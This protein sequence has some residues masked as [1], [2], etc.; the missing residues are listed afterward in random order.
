MQKD[1]IH[2]IGAQHHYEEN[3]WAVPIRCIDCRTVKKMAP[4]AINCKDCHTDF[5]FSVGSQ[6]HFKQVGWAAP[7]RCAGCR[8]TNKAKVV[9]ETAAGGGSDPAAST[10]EEV[11]TMVAEALAEKPAE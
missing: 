7:S 9:A 11:I 8:K 10:E 1:F 2:S 5:N 4:F 6:I 3:G